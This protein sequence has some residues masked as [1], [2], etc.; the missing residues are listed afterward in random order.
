GRNG[1]GLYLLPRTHRG[2]SGVVAGQSRQM[3]SGP[4]GLRRRCADAGQRS[5]RPGP[6]RR[7]R[8]SGEPAADEGSSGALKPGRVLE[9]HR[10]SLY[11]PSPPPGGHR[12]GMGEGRMWGTGLPGRSVAAA[13]AFAASLPFLTS[14]NKENT[15]VPPPPP[16]VKVSAPLNQV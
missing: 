11:E 9:C 6:A 2:G 13:L 14:C 7:D 12:S 4:Q 10:L 3:A 5:R 8:V 15:Y 16:A 1:A